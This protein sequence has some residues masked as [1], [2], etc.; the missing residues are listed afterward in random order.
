MFWKKNCQMYFRYVFILV[1]YDVCINQ[2]EKNVKVDH[3]ICHN[4]ILRIPNQFTLN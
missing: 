4:P 2:E 3:F 1:S